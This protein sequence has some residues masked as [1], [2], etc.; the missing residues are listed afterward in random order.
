MRITKRNLEMKANVAI[1]YVDQLERWSS[2]LLRKLLVFVVCVFVNLN[3]WALQVVLPIRVS[4][5]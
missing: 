5:F 2:N 4:N 3:G 1:L